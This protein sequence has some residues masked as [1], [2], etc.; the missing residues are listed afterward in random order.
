M[1]NGPMF[2]LGSDFIGIEYGERAV[3][4]SPTDIDG[5]IEAVQHGRERTRAGKRASAVPA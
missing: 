2:G 1:M 3:N 4:I 5:F